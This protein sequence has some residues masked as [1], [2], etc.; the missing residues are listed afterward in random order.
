MSKKAATEDKLGE[1][2]SKVADVMLNAL[3]AYDEVEKLVVEREQEKED[4]TTI[5][6]IEAREPSAAL[7]GAITKFLKDNEITCNSAE[8]EGMTD[9]QKKLIE[10]RAKRGKVVGLDGLPIQEPEDQSDQS[11]LKALGLG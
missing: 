11:D 5:V 1:L 9:L 6:T 10:K 2:H 8:A 4:G 7:L 3:D